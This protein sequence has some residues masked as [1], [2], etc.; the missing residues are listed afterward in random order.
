MPRRRQQPEPVAKVFGEAVR[1]RRVKR[2]WTL[3]DLGEELGS[4]DGRYVGELERG[5][6]TPTLTMAKRIADAL[7]IS[8]RDLVRDL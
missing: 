3:D 6:H 4:Q 7:D 1:D 2:G 8:L 5:F